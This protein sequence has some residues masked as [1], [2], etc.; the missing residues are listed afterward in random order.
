ME[1]EHECIPALNLRKQ[2]ILSRFMWNVSM[3]S[4]PDAKYMFVLLVCLSTSLI[5]VI[6]GGTRV[7][8]LKLKSMVLSLIALILQWRMV[9]IMLVTNF[10]A[11]FAAYTTALK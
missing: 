2:Q 5:D 7:A 6:T 1:I 9:K 10:D 8:P 3:F 4:F 11:L